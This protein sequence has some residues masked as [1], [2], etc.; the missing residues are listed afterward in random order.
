MS[1]EFLFACQ[2]HEVVADHLER[3][4]RRLSS[5][6]QIDQQAC[7]DRTVRLDL[8]SVLVVADQVRATKKLFEEPEEISMVHL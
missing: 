2:T 3:P 5:R 6:P 7:D 8:D 1:D 4:L